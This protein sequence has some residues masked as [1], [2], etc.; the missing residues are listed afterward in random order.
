MEIPLTPTNL[1]LT[2]E[3]TYFVILLVFSCLLWLVC[4]IT[5]VPII[6]LLSGGF[7][8]WLLHGVLVA[9]I[10][11]EAVKLDANQMPELNKAFA[12]ICARLNV[13]RIPELYLM[14]QG[15]ALN[16]FATRHCARDF[17]VLYSDLLEAYG[18][19]SDEIKFL[20]GHEIGHIRSR[21]I[22]KNVLLLPGLF[23]PLLG[24][25]YSRACESSCDRHGAFAS[26]NAESSVRAMMILSGGK[27]VGRDL[28]ADAFS[29]QH[30]RS[31]GFFVS[32]HELFSSYPTL[33]KRVSDLL[34]IEHNRVTPKPGRNP[35]AILIGLF[36]PGARFGI[37]GVLI[38][39]YL[40]IIFA[41]VAVP[42][43]VKAKKQAQALI[44]Q[45]QEKL[46][47]PQNNEGES[48]PAPTSTP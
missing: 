36:L 29:I 44:Q 21:H 38:V 30:H 15:G 6:G 2:K 13:L 34:D 14:Q 24:S 48:N 26:E 46:K 22:L 42:A 27:H 20:L 33:S 18:P 9:R 7:I 28:V 35:L 31:R 37:I 23:L 5:I 47:A 32:L 39:F 19:E 43:F 4:A 8:V 25:A 12:N 1:T 40:V 3:R 10:K 41:S 11:S 45:Q 16:A 17:V